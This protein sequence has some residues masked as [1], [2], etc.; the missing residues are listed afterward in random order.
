MDKRIEAICVAVA[1][2]VST[3]FSGAVMAGPD[4]WLVT[5]EEAAQV[6]VEDG[7]VQQLA[8]AVTGPGPEIVVR[9]PRALEKIHAP[10]D[11]LVTFEPGD[12]GL[13]PDMSSFKATLV[14]FFDIDL[15]SRVKDHLQGT[16]LDVK[17]ANLPRGRHRIRIAIRDTQGNPNERD[18]NVTILAAE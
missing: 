14:G 4:F 12:S 13:P 8:A 17:D 15:T 11:I 16:R 10:I 18:L 6:R 5:A 9:N 3:L 1:L 2:S 7:Q